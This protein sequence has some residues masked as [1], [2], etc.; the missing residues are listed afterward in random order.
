MI[1]LGDTLWGRLNTSCFRLSLCVYWLSMTEGFWP[2]FVVVVVVVVVLIPF[3][4]VWTSRH[5]IAYIK[6]IPARNLNNKRGIEWSL[7]AFASMRAVRLFLRARAVANFSCE[8]RELKKTQ[9]AKR[10]RAWFFEHE[11]ASTPVTFSGINASPCQRK[12]LALGT[13]SAEVIIKR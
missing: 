4:K 11:Q 12:E 2:F 3:G 10:I 7:Q 5:V 1:R 6:N 8:Q 9:K 13:S